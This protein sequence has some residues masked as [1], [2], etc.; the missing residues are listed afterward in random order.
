M[1]TDSYSQLKSKM[2]N[3]GK[4]ETDIDVYYSERDRTIRYGLLAISVLSFWIK[5]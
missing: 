5:I 3:V 1:T 2:Y 4:P